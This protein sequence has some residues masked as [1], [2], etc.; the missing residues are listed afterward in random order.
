MSLD[1]F[2]IVGSRN[3]RYVMS[4]ATRILLVIKRIRA[5][6]FSL[7]LLSQVLKR[8]PRKSPVLGNVFRLR[9]WK[10]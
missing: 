8:P 7:H 5:K 4:D 9:T 2:A 10:T 1:T 3:A 6:V